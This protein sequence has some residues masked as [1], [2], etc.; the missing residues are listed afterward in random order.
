MQF[1]SSENYKEKYLNK[2]IYIYKSLE[3]KYIDNNQI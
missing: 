1:S 3:S 2:I